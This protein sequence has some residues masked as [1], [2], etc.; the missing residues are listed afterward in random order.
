[1][2][3]VVSTWVAYHVDGPENKSSWRALART[4]ALGFPSVGG[5]SAWASPEES[6]AAQEATSSAQVDGLRRPLLTGTGNGRSARR[7]CRHHLTERDDGT[8]MAMAIVRLPRG[9]LVTPS[10]PLRCRQ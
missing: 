4:A 8:V 7:H 3:D 6:D 2:Q 1:M 9:G 5:G 10:F